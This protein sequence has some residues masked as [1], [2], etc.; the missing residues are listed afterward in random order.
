MQIELQAHAGAGEGTSLGGTFDG[1]LARWGQ[2]LPLYGECGARLRNA[3]AGAGS[4]YASTDEH[5]ASL[6]QPRST[7]SATGAQRPRR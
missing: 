3:I 2:V 7:S 4:T 6:S 1:L 5:L